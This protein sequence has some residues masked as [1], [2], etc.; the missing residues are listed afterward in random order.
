MGEDSIS[1]RPGQAVPVIT[2]VIR[3]SRMMHRLYS[4]GP[5]IS[6][7][8]NGICIRAVVVNHTLHTQM[9]NEKAKVF[10]F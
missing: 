10:I 3:T 8:L 9:K 5:M 2:H 1:G 6:G 4:P 7:Y